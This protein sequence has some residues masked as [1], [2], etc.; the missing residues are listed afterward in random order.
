MKK[1]FLI[2]PA[3]FLF[4]PA[5][6]HAATDHLL[7]S[8]VQIDPSGGAPYDFVEIYN[9]TPNDVDLYKM[10]LV[11]RTKT[12]STDSSLMSWDSKSS[13]YP[14]VIKAHGRMLTSRMLQKNLTL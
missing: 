3:L 1:F 11:K 7:I 12:G 14:I 13:D 4:F 10:K 8:Q 9:P 6:V 5:F 2:A